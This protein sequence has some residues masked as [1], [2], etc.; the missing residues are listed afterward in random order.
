MTVSIILPVFVCNVY[1]T[2]SNYTGLLGSWGI[3]FSLEGQGTELTV[4]QAALELIP[5]SQ[6]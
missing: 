5:A 1:V 4:T 3:F 2:I 6:Y